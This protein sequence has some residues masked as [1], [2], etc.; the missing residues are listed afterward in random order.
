MAE[1]EKTT[2]DV[3]SDTIDN[4]LLNKLRAAVLG[5]NDGIVSTSSVVMGVAGA[6]SDRT[7][8]VTAGLAALVA[9]ALSMAVG[10]YVS[11]SSQSDAEKAYI[12]R[13]KRD[14]ERDPEG[15]L[16]VLQREYMKQGVAEATALQ[17]AKELT[18]KDALRSHL[19]MHFNLDPDD[20]NSPMQAAIASLLSFTA[21]GLV[22]FLTIVL[23][24]AKYRISVTI[25]AVLIALVITGYLSATAG[26]ASRK[27]AVLR[28]VLGGLAAMIITYYVGVLFGTTIS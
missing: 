20:L 24:P 13:E 18:V 12:D 15:E 11:V 28:V 3:P 22:P 7:T 17:V 26:K 2:Y 6:T 16:H 1:Q 14:L 8:I 19:R 10:E 21:G 23:A 4:G 25:D 5:A 9:G 27:R